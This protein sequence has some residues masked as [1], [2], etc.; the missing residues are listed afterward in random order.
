MAYEKLY[1]SSWSESTLAG[2]DCLGGF[3]K[4]HPH[5]S[6]RTLEVS[7]VARATA[8]NRANVDTLK[9]IEEIIQRG[10][11]PPN[12]IYNLDETGVQTTQKPIK[13]IAQTGA[14]HVA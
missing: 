4:R 14:R 1:P 2:K 7:S 13:V 6:I 12:R 10:Q 5:M 11:L 8:F 9:K 3:F